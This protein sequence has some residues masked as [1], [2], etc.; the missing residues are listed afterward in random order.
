MGVLPNLIAVTMRHCGH[1]SV[2]HAAG[3]T[4]LRVSDQKKSGRCSNVSLETRSA[5]TKEISFLCTAKNLA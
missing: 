4:S 3:F 5:L 2:I 1:I